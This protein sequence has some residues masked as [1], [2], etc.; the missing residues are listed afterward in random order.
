MVL[1]VN[2]A[3]VAVQLV[4]GVAVHS[5]GL[6]ADAGHNLTD[7]AAVLVSL[8]ALA[9]A[10]RAPTAR[11]SFGYHRATILAAQA[12]AASI[13]IVTGFLVWEAVRRLLDP[14]V[15]HGAPV[16]WTALVA[17]TVNLASARL[18][19]GGHEHD[20]NMRSVWL[21]MMSDAAASV[22][23]LVA[24][25]L[26]WWRGG[27]YRLDPI[28]S[29]IVSALI[30]WRAIALLRDTA[31]VLLEATPAHLDVDELTA[32]VATVAG[33]ESLHDLHAWGL[34]SEVAALSAHVVLDGHP[35]LEE[36][37]VVGARIKDVLRDRFA[38]THAT[39]ELECESC[40]PDAA[41]DP[42]TIVVP[43]VAVGS[44]PGTAIDTHDHAH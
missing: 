4:V 24:G 32:A 7:V 27:W 36:A 31:D 6:L 10:V 17:V 5:V 44:A 35:T 28:A 19:H 33:V 37:Q 20:L 15:V 3:L 26:I 41:V 22:G 23:V 39:L 14:G 21:H 40:A 43:A 30:A 25:A 8:F 9:L 29:L 34:S 42:C 1:G 11:R 13:L 2:L 12:N 18:L 38:I 16:V